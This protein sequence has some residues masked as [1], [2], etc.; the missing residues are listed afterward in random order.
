MKDRESSFCGIL[1]EKGVKV[2]KQRL[3][4]LEVLSANKGHHLTAEEIFD[5]V[6]S[7][8]PT[9]GLAT[10][11]RV[12]LLLTELHLVDRINLNDGYTRYEIGDIG[13]NETKHH[14]HHLIC[15]SCGE[16]FSFEGD[17]LETLESSIETT[18]GFKVVDHELKFYGYCKECRCQKTLHDK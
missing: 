12:I 11:Y 6:R 15:L 9:I 2:T 13:E 3:L 4:V 14:H 17:L 1:R 8:S 16:V 5:L 10:I 7:D 18:T